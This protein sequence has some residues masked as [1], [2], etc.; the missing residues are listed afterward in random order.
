MTFVVPSSFNPTAVPRIPGRCMRSGV[1]L[2]WAATAV[3]TSGLDIDSSAVVAAIALSGARSAQA[4][5]II[6]F[7]K[8]DLICIFSFPF[9]VEFP[10]L[11]GASTATGV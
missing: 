5:A 2:F 1:T 10:C 7:F 6:N 3:C 4:P 9:C 8:V 11:P